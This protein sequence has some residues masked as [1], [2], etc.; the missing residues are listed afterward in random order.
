MS[1]Q[2]ISDKVPKYGPAIPPVGML[3]SALRADGEAIDLDFLAGISGAAFRTCF[4]EEGVDD[5]LWREGE[6]IA[7]N[8][9]PILGYELRPILSGF[10]H[11]QKLD[12]KLR[13]RVVTEVQVAIDGGN[14]VLVSGSFG[15]GMVL[16]YDKAKQQY[17]LRQM[18]PW[19]AVHDMTHCPPWDAGKE[20]EE[21][22]EQEDKLLDSTAGVDLAVLRKRG[23]SLPRK[24]L[25]VNA[26][27]HAI[28]HARKKAVESRHFGLEA[29]DF[30]AKRL[31]READEQKWDPQIYGA[32]LPMQ[33]IFL[34]LNRAMAVHFLKEAAEEFDGSRK[35]TL[36]ECVAIYEESAH[37][38]LTL[39]ASLHNPQAYY[40]NRDS[41]KTDPAVP[42]L[43]SESLKKILGIERRAVTMLE[44]VA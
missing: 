5:V 6:K 12:G 10:S 23:K 31:D 38:W 2:N 36:G 37:E 27:R 17:W 13:E 44:A 16:G 34:A 7:D 41:V 39:Q 9:L 32:S 35:S 26:L 29:I 42:Q 3:W 19:N 15:W 25:A 43:V 28:A 8:A 21:R 14:A 1:A 24:G 4:D 22:W 30:F 33:V 40:E 18:A 11:G 20:Q